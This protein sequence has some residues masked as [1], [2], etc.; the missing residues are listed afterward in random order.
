MDASESLRCGALRQDGTPCRMPPLPGKATCWAHAAETEAAR[1]A[2]RSK[3][4][5]GRSNTARLLAS[6]PREYQDVITK[7]LDLM[8][9]VEAGTVQPRRA[10]VAGSLA[11]H[12]LAWL[13]FAHELGQAADLERRL[14]ALEA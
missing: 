14:D 12:V 11:A 8:R 4:G 1:A 3:G 5:K 2:A 13:R 9:D 7:L 10:E 6:L